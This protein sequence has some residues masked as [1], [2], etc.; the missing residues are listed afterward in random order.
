MIYGRIEFMEV[1]RFTGLS[2]KLVKAASWTA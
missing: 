2:F 1:D